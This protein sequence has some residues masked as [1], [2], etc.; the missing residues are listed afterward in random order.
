[1]FEILPESREQHSRPLGQTVTAVAV[2]A[3]IILGTL[4]EAHAAPELPPAPPDTSMI[5]IPAPRI[6]QPS[7]AGTS[8][9]PATRA[10]ADGAMVVPVVE[11]PRGL[12][13][14]TL[15]R[16]PFDPRAF[17]GHLPGSG[18]PTPVAPGADSSALGGIVVTSA[19]ADE[20]PRLLAAGQLQPPPGLEGVAGRV[21]LAFIVDTLGRAEPLSVKV[22]S[23][24]AP[25]FE[26]PTGEMVR[27]SRFAPGRSGGRP[28]RVLVEQA[29]VFD[30][31]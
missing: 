13:A 10:A 4:R 2:H 20:P 12:P 14:V 17:T 29:V 9:A 31:R 22:V 6:P 11:M 1:M 25:A 18:S 16:D 21:V 8:A 3:V 27:R 15:G 5:F 23:S 28:V 7:P 26:Q 19:E 24:S 30:S